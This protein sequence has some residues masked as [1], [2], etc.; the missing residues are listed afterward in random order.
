MS[1]CCSTAKLCPTF[2]NPHRLQQARL[3]YASQ[4]PAV[5][6]SSCLL[7]QWCYPTISSSATH[8]SCPQSFP[9]S[10]S[11]QWVGSSHH[12]AKVLELQHQSFQ[13][14]FKG[15]F[16]WDWLVWFPCS[17]KRSQKGFSSTTI[18][19]QQFFS[20]QPSIWSNSHISTWLLGKIQLWLYGPFSQNDVC[21][22][23]CY[24][25]LS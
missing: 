14:I 5:C 2:C 15:D 25:G 6:S 9:A 22:L 8:F 21:F 12:I 19:K 7:S 4:S 17:A 3:P 16:L 11:F 23:I 20:A 24:L 13:R 10:G 1:C 18:W